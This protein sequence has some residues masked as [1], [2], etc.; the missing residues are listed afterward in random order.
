MRLSAS[1]QRLLR[2]KLKG[3]VKAQIKTGKPFIAESLACH[4]PGLSG[5]ETY[6]VFTCGLGLEFCQHHTA[7]S[8]EAGSSAAC[9]CGAL[10]GNR[11]VNVHD[12]HRCYQA[13]CQHLFSGLN[14]SYRT[15]TREEIP[16]PF[17]Q[18]SIPARRQVEFGE[19]E[20]LSVE[21]R[22]FPTEQAIRQKEA[23][24]LKSEQLEASGLSPEQV[25]K[26]LI[27]RK[28]FEQEAHADDCGSD[29]GPIDDASERS[30]YALSGHVDD[31]VKYSFWNSRE[32]HDLVV[33]EDLEN[34]VRDDNFHL[35]YLL[36][37]ECDD[38]NYVFTH[39]HPRANAVYF[40]DLDA[41]MS[42]PSRSGRVEVMEVFGGLGGVSKIAIRR[43][44]VT[45]ENF[46]VVTGT[47]LT[48]PANQRSLE[49]YV[50][51][52]MRGALRGAL[53]RV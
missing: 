34:L 28:K 5:Y 10:G 7:M 49:E 11:P 22:A 29:T 15:S 42:S 8:S 39:A 26:A 53:R 6:S 52:A 46:D 32:S 37:S 12:I 16:P 9:I 24:K 44:L 19:T 14:P 36:G 20:L 17:P 38:D 27:K 2:D 3:V 50:R 30:L 35:N 23:R 25:K 33:I 43:K 48:V 31:A 40:T 4:W 45:G 1:L 41:Y 47:D 51:K 18:E 21:C 13:V